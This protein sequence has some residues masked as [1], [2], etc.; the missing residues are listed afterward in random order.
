M[1]PTTSTTCS[2]D[3]CERRRAEMS[4]CAAHAQ[5][6][7]RTGSAG[8]P[9]IRAV[10]RKPKRKCAAEGCEKVHYCGGYCTVHYQRKRKHGTI[11]SPAKPLADLN[12]N[13]RGNSAGYRAIHVRIEV[14]R[15]KASEHSCVD[16]GDPAEQWSYNNSGDAERSE[17]GVG[18]Y[19]TE[20]ANYDPRCRRC[21]F[22]FD[23][24]TSL[25]HVHDERLC[26][27]RA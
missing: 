4:L 5:R 15:G 2:V 27:H 23:C 3:G 6:V 25:D 1:Q 20:L 21:H 7:R 9:A 19:S 16:C 18:R 22:R 8:G 13:W 17:D 14:Q 11:E 12:P 10:A 26:A 24:E